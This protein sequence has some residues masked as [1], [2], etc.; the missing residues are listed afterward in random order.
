MRNREMR[1]MQ[2]QAPRPRPWSAMTLPP[3]RGLVQLKSA[4]FELSQYPIYV[5]RSGANPPGSAARRPTNRIESAFLRGR[6][7]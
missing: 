5:I 1:K 2:A 3:Q 7:Q 6:G 4:A